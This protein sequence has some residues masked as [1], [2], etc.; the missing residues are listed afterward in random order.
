MAHATIGK[1]A[2]A[3]GLGVETVRFYEREGLIPEPPRSEAGY[4]L[5]PEDTI[6]R[7]LFILRAKGLGFTLVEIREL[8]SLSAAPEA[9]CKDVRDRA[10]TKIA[11]IEAR[12][13]QLL[14]MKKAL[15]GLVEQCTGVGPTTDCPILEAL[16]ED[17]ARCS[18]RNAVL[19][20]AR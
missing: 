3:V 9:C 14:A 4:R 20:G 5:Y 11:D 16:E 18:V 19:Q 1:V 13:A 12:V 2:K 7:L 8:L 10:Q 15:E 17:G 6:P